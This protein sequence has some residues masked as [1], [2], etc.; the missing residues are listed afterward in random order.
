MRRS[1]SVALSAAC[2]AGGLALGA[3]P[4]AQA[5]P[6]PATAAGVT[7][8]QYGHNGPLWISATCYA[9]ADTDWYLRI[10]CVRG[11]GL[12]VWVNGTLVHGPGTSWAQC[13]STFLEIDDTQ[14]VTF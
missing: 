6:S 13:A 11:S 1:L 14:I 9:T 10:H 3:A 2:L 12:G 4:A 8:C 7:N 5:A